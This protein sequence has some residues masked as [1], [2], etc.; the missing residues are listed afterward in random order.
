M[1]VTAIRAT[2]LK[3]Q[4]KSA[5][6]PNNGDDLFKLV[7]EA[8]WNFRRNGD[9]VVC[10]PPEGEP[11][12]FSLGNGDYR[13]LK[14]NKSRFRRAGLFDTVDKLRAEQR[15]IVAQRLAEDRDKAEQ[16]IK[17]IEANNRLIESGA[18]VGRRDQALHDLVKRCQDVGWR[19]RTVGTD[20]SHI[21]V[22]PPN[23]KRPIT[24]ACGSGVS[25]Y[26]TIML[27]KLNKA[28]LAEAEAAKAEQDK[29]D[30][31][32]KLA[33]DRAKGYIES[34]QP[35]HQSPGQDTVVQ[36]G[37]DEQRPEPAESVVAAAPDSGTAGQEV[38]EGTGPCPGGYSRVNGI[39]VAEW[40]WALTPIKAKDRQAVELLLEDA[41]VHYGCIQGDFVGRNWQSVAK[42]R[43]A[44]HPEMRS[45][46]SRARAERMAAVAEAN[47][48]LLLSPS[49]FSAPPAAQPAPA[50]NVVALKHDDEDY[51]ARL[52]RLMGTSRVFTAGDHDVI[53]AAENF[54]AG[55][56]DL[57]DDQHD[58]DGPCAVQPEEPAVLDRRQ[59]DGVPTSTATSTPAPDPAPPTPSEAV[60]AD[61]QPAPRP[62]TPRVVN[63][64]PPTARV[65]IAQMAANIT[66]SP[67]P[68]PQATLS[69]SAT[70]S[71]GAPPAT[72][73]AAGV[74]LAA[75]VE[76]L[77]RF[78]SME[79]ENRLISAELENLR[80]ALDKAQ[81]EATFARQQGEAL[82]DQC[83]AKDNTIRRLRQELQ[84]QARDVAAARELQALMANLMGGSQAA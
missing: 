6:E 23:G 22:T 27:T 80:A 83:I 77:R 71:A 53:A 59:P 55:D 46:S 78:A 69:A 38:A 66:T 14:N 12:T 17:N 75:M 1:T 19:T 16:Q 52:R 25:N 24:I 72:A 33:A 18:S 57:L 5:A 3:R 10:Y 81:Q 11:I 34:A 67:R 63:P 2:A 74:D 21:V 29:Q 58:D 61:E 62:L 39:E 20:Q 32:E 15:E 44:Q 4:K 60:R 68:Q 26:A 47:K 36:N 41:T 49:L 28:G 65:G 50:G 54:M 84:D 79:A 82:A 48:A 8:Q 31:A 73:A 51:Q 56:Y 64:A 43:K 45:P 70:V 13:V 37:R 30:R 35:D 7:Q 9:V 76:K 42:H 40:T